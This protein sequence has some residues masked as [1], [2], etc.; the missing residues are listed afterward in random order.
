MSEDI[1]Q[2][3]RA[4]GL[5]EN[6]RTPELRR[7]LLTWGGN[8]TGN[9]LSSRGT[10]N[11]RRKGPGARSGDGQDLHVRATGIHPR[12]TLLGDIEQTHTER[13]LNLKTN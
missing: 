4:I 7:A 3:R 6:A 8:A 2:P 1:A 9:R 5:E 11:L 13:I 10:V 12:Q